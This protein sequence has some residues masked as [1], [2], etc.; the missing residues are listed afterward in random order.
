MHAAHIYRRPKVEKGD[1]R[2][3]GFRHSD[4][5]PGRRIRDRLVR[6]K[7]GDQVSTVREVWRCRQAVRVGSHRGRV[8]GEPGSEYCISTTKSK[9]AVFL[10][11]E[12]NINV[13][14]NKFTAVDLL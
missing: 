10:Y 8:N 9:K 13:W 4:L 14:Q 2:E 1:N 11:T 6:P 3:D 12:R 5:Q 7:T